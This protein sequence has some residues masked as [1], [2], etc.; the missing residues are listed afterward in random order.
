ML[1]SAAETMLAEVRRWST[2]PLQGQGIPSVQ[3]VKWLLD[4]WEHL[5]PT[6]ILLRSLV[7]VLLMGSALV[8]LRPPERL[9]S[10]ASALS[11]FLLF[12]LLVLAQLL[13]GVLAARAPEGVALALARMTRGL[14][15]P[16]LPLA[17]PL[18]WAVRL[19]LRA[20]G[21]PEA[22]LSPSGE[23]RDLPLWANQIEGNGTAIEEEERQMIRGIFGLEATTARA[24]MVPRIDI[25][26][27]DTQTPLSKVV[28]VIVQRGYSRIPLYEGT[29]DNVVG[30]IYAKDLLDSLVNGKSPPSLQALARPAHFIPETKKIDELLQELRRERVHLAI[31]V[32]EYGGT[33][34]L[35]TIE[36]LLEEIVGEIEDE[37]DLRE[38]HIQHISD[39]EAVMDARVSIQDLN[40]LFG[41]HI[42]GGDF[43]TVGGFVYT[44]LGKIPSPGDEITAEGVKATVLSTVGHRIKQ[45][46]ILR[47]P[48]R[49]PKKE[50]GKTE[51]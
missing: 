24:I 12:I 26:A 47:H 27:V 16:L 46:R 18:A 51:A 1:T 6:F 3:A 50:P 14:S 42:R 15:L 29:M 33:A 48:S 4:R 23:E 13:P 37:F 28:D 9:T 8:L 31:V 5:T 19:L 36:D 25:V 45:V 21:Q 34:G 49:Q 7:L 11:A 35:V 38:V 40:E 30:I 2:R 10:W 43:D 17:I 44:K 32:D 39:N 41:L 20:V 22:P